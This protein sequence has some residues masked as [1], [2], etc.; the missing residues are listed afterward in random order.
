MPNPDLQ[1]T[2]DDAVQEVLGLLT[3][4]DVTYDPDQD[5][6][7]TIART[8]NRALRA[9]ALEHEW[10]YYSSVETVGIVHPGD[11]DVVLRSTVRLRKTGDDSV[12]FVR[13][14]TDEVV[15]WAYILPRDALHKY[16]GRYGG[17]WAS[18]TRE[19]LTFSRP[20]GQSLAG[21]EIQVPVM[22]EPKMFDIPPVQSDP[23]APLVPI[24]D[25]TRA[26][27]LDYD[28]PDAVV[29][30]AAYMY[31]QGDPIMQPRVQTLEAQFN[32][33]KYQLIERDDQHTDSVFMND[34]FVPITN[35]IDGGG[36]GWNGRH[37]H[38]DERR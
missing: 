10:S 21:L 24:D 35:S 13:P 8:L 28:Y 22:R 15:E 30:R 27:L 4:L 5:R 23:D 34:F 37:P 32:D 36:M 31:A 7:R 25:D 26:Q 29:L 38:S 20:L 9:N 2:L 33:L 19:R 14:G 6:Y 1:M 11:T 12:R 17:I 18:V 16:S 3:G